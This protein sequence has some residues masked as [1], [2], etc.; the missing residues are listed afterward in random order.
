[1]T[2]S[3][4]PSLDYRKRE[5]SASEEIRSVLLALREEAEQN[6]WTFEVGYTHA[7][8]WKIEQITGLKVPENF[9]DAAKKQNV[10]AKALI[11][12][13]QERIFLERRSARDVMP[14]QFNWADHNAVTP[15]KDQ[16]S[17]GSCWAFGTHGAFEGSY[18]V[19]FGILINSAEQDT[20]DCSG[21]GSCDGGWL[22][23]Q[24]LVDKGSADE[25]D[26]G[27]TAQQGACR[28]DVSRLFK[29]VTWSYVDSTS[30][31]PSVEALKQALCEH[32][33]LAIDVHVTP[34]FQAYTH[35]VFNETD[36]SD[37]INHCITLIGWDDAKQ[38][39][40]IKNSWG[41][42]W[43]EAGFM[44]IAYGS[45]KV[46]YGA[47]WVLAKASPSLWDSVSGGI[48]YT[49]G[50]VGIGT[51]QPSHALHVKTAGAVGLFES[52]GNNAY[53]RVA[54]EEG[55][56]KR[57]E[58]AN[59]PGGRLALWTAAGGDTLNI[60]IDGNVGIGTTSPSVKLEVAGTVFISSGDLSV[61]GVSRL[62]GGVIIDRKH[63]VQLQCYQHTKSVAAIYAENKKQAAAIFCVGE[64]DVVEAGYSIWVFKPISK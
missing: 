22:A 29:A 47:A 64:A 61:M 9:L 55:I 33:P 31:I 16:G 1:M 51:S 56:E 63:L 21:A 48:A 24:Y 36:P 54:T 34:A 30:E 6:K 8:D 13:E 17:C 3:I 15:V 59:R 7:M 62:F 2:N 39:W 26:Y 20:L 43:G 19:E 41:Q 49:K 40:R 50:N 44:W 25:A 10:L 12:P 4:T 57:V 18:A 23:F 52:T 53:L 27:Y 11:K 58:L 45:N 46:G 38:A 60:T 37:D 42:G 5:L 28:S 32:G 35:G 14:H